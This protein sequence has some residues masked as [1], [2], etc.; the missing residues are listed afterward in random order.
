MMLIFRWF[1]IAYSLFYVVFGSMLVNN[2]FMSSSVQNRRL[3]YSLWKQPLLSVFH[4]HLV[5]YPTASN[6]NTSWNWGSLAGICLGLQIITGICLAMHYTPH[7]D[8]AFSSVQHIMRD[9]PSGWLL[10]YLHANGAS[11]FFIVVYIHLFRGIY[12]SSYCQ[13]REFVWILGVVILLRMIVTAFI[14]YVLPWGE[15]VCP[16]GGVENVQELC[17][18]FM[19]PKIP[20]FQRIGPHNQDVISVIVGS[21]L[22]DG[23][24][25]KRCVSTRFH[26]HVSQENVEYIMWLHKFFNERG[27]CS[28]TKP[29]ILTQIQKGNKVYYSIKIRT[30]SFRSFNFLYNLFY[31][32]KVKCIPTNIGDFLTPLALAIWFMDD[33]GK[34]SSSVLIHTN[35]FTKKEV[36]ML[37][38]VLFQKYHRRT[39]TRKKRSKDP[40]R[41]YII[42][43][44]K[45]D[46][47]LFASLVKPH[48]IQ[49]MHYKLGQ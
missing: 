26:I 8:L 49:S 29:K 37:Q 43:I 42:D 6:L 12:Y 9:V 15:S 41:G 27:Y 2:I 7:V 13:P 1:T 35:S 5:V 38:K 21:L 3:L 17:L 28:S 47:P 34:N 10:R 19:G 16:R 20:G 4:D 14:G 11:F 48:M 45:K 36:E 22:G 18:F 30:W 33:G 44:L 25:E 31:K 39:T 24:G 23:W 32:D 46:L 40:D